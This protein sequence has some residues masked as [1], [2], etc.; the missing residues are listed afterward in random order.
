MEDLWS[1]TASVLGV[2][3][4][5]GAGAF[6]RQQ[7]WLT[8]EADRSLANLTANLLL[9]GYFIQRIVVSPQ[10]D[11]MGGVWAATVFGFAITAGGILLAFS[12]ARTIGPWIGLRDDRSQRAFG[13]CVGVCNYGFIPFPLAEQFYPGAVIDLILHNVGVN[14]A[15]WSIGIVVVSGSARG[16]WR[17]A[18]LNPAFLSVILALIFRQFALGDRIPGSIMYVIENLGS[19]AI[20]MGLMLSGAIIVDFL[21]DS[22][23]RGSVGVLVSTVLLRHLVFPIMML[24]AASFFAAAMSLRQVILLQAAMPVAVFPIVLVRLY[25]CDTETAFKVV[26]TSSILGILTIP[27]WLGIGQWW[28]A[29]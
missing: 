29:L 10:Q 20:P 7:D 17:K 6:C 1:I 23:W 16:G 15:L 21:R 14:L 24:A 19:C 8:P 4:L 5:M 26:I 22:A 3:L 11:T 28:L 2:F 13:L 25:Q 12:F 18:L 27:I 9:P